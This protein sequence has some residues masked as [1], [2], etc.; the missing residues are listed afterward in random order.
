MTNSTN[1]TKTYPVINSLARG[2]LID[3]LSTF[4]VMIVKNIIDISYKQSP[5]YK[6]NEILLSSFVYSIAASVS[7]LI[8]NDATQQGHRLIGGIEG[9]AFKY[10]SRYVVLSHVYDEKIK[11]S[12]IILKSTIGSSNNFLYEAC[13]SNEK[14][15]NDSRVASLFSV[16]LEITES[17]IS[18]FLLNDQANLI[19]TGVLGFTAGA[20]GSFYAE[21]ICFPLLDSIHLTYDYLEDT[22]VSFIPQELP[23]IINYYGSANNITN[24]L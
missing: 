15:G 19:E 22:F 9:G 6:T 24:E 20:T 13:N 23:S 12:D 3:G 21:Y 4:T 11:T 5:V 1:D 16:I 2:F 8:R 14:C 17:Y 10:T 18:K 7:Y